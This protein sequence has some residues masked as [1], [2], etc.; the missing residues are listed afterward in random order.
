MKQYVIDE[1]RPR[2]YQK[3]KKYLD[4]TC[5]ASD[6]DGLYWVR[7]SDEILT[8]LQRDH[9]ACGPFYFAAE[10]DPQRIGFELLVR[11]R[12]RI[13]CNCMAYATEG[14]RNWLIQRVDDIFS[15]LEIKT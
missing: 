9:L 4:E 6:L 7:L 8:P 3:I 11:T 1:L 2:D 14:Q 13:R 15:R 12:N 10:L 5:E